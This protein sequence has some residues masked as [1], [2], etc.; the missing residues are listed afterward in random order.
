MSLAVNIEM[1]NGFSSI[2][3]LITY[4]VEAFQECIGDNLIR[5]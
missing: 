4:R 2:L 1:I 3:E 5:R